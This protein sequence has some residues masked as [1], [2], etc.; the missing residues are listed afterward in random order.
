VHAFNKMQRKVMN[1]GSKHAAHNAAERYS[2][3]LGIQMY[4]E[5][6]FDVA[7]VNAVPRLY[8]FSMDAAANDDGA[9][10]RWRYFTVANFITSN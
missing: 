10:Y 2:N 6:K 3:N 5:H 4:F 9:L 1:D 7:P 8:V